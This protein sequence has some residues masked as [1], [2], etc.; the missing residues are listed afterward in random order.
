MTAHKGRNAGDPEIPADDA[1][2]LK[3]LS[4]E[5]KMLHVKPFMGK[6]DAA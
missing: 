3:V 1:E 6:C 2:G 5:Q 4:S